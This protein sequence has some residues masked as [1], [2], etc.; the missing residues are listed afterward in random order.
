M[1]VRVKDYNRA[2]SDPRLS[3]E[4]WERSLR[5]LQDPITPDAAWRA[6]NRALRENSRN[7]PIRRPSQ[8]LAVAI[9]FVLLVFGMLLSLTSLLAEKIAGL[10]WFYDVVPPVIA[11]V[12]GIVMFVLGTFLIYRTVLRS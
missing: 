11:L 2:V 10:G 12:T 6:S 8:L 7:E 5:E 4:E 3:R 1:A 9:G